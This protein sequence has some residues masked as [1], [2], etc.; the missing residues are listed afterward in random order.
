[1]DKR[2]LE[3]GKQQSFIQAVKS[4][5]FSPEKRQGNLNIALSLTVFTGAIVFL[6]NWGELLAV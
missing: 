5:L 6:R 1:M 3:Q 4:E 2:Q